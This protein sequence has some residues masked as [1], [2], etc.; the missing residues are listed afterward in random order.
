MK[1]FLVIFL[2]LCLLAFSSCAEKTPGENTEEKITY[3]EN[4]NTKD[5][6]ASFLDGEKTFIDSET[7]KESTI[8]TLHEDNPE[9]MGRVFRYAA[10]D[11]DGDGSDEYLF[12]C[13]IGGETAVL[14][15]EG[16]SWKSYRLHIRERFGIKTD[17]EMHV[18]GNADHEALQRVEFSDGEMKRV[19]TLESDY[20]L[21]VHKNS[22]DE[23]SA[24][25][26]E[27]MWESFNKK[28][29]VEWTEMYPAFEF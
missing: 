10:V 8:Y 18:L 12:E 6:L 9:Y 15:K 21:G 14:H 26:A 22:S 7:G 17:G 3:G 29:N 25:E 13:D 19:F 4:V 20:G 23:I 11:L 24:D 1:K 16:D 2:A 5:D 27:K 28:Q